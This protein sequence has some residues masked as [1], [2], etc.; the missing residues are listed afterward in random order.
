MTAY[1]VCVCVFSSVH[2]R[3]EWQK[4]VCAGP[5][6]QLK[7]IRYHHYDGL[8]R[9]FQLTSL[10]AEKHSQRK[11]LVDIHIGEP[12][13]KRAKLEPA[14]SQK[15]RSEGKEEEEEE[16]ERK[17]ESVGGGGG[18]GGKAK[19]SSKERDWGSFSPLVCIGMCTY[20]VSMETRESGC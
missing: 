16:E 15:G 2:T 7:H 17:Q 6:K 14:V 20:L 18:G 4:H 12:V 11:Q 3:R 10:A 5:G 13:S 1:R 19:G 9:L 8:L